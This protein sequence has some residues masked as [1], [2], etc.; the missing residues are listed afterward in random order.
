MVP[1]WVNWP[2]TSWR[3]LSWGLVIIVI[4]LLA[5]GLGAAHWALVLLAVVSL[6]SIAQTAL[7]RTQQEQNAA[8]ARAAERTLAENSTKLEYVS[9]AIHDAIWDWDLVDD[10]TT[11]SEGIHTLFGHPASEANSTAEWWLER[12]H[13]EDRDRVVTGLEELLASSHNYWSCEYR[14]LKA[15]GSYADVYDRGY[16]NRRPHGTPVRMIGAMTDL[17]QRN[18][19]AKALA[20][21]E[22][23]LRLFFD[24]ALDAMVIQ[25]NMGRYLDANPAACKLFDLCREQLIGRSDRDF[26]ESGEE[27]RARWQQFLKDGR[28][29]GQLVLTLLDGTRRTVDVS[30]TANYL[31][32]RHFS[33]LRDITEQHD[34]ELQLRQAHKMEAV[35]RLAGGIAHDF[36]NLLNVIVGYTELIE[37]KLEPANLL[38]RY[39]DKVMYS[40]E[41]AAELTD[42]LLAFSSRKHLLAPVIL[43]LNDVISSLADRLP[44]LLGDDIEFAPRCAPDLGNVRVDRSQM[45]QVITNL[46]INA[47]DAMP[48][49]GTLTVETAQV[50]VDSRHLQPGVKMNPG[51]YVLLTVSDTGTGMDAE[52]QAHIFEPF[53]T[54]KDIGKGVGLGLA[55]VYGIVRQSGGFIRVHSEVGAGTIFRV[56]FPLVIE[57]VHLVQKRESLPRCDKGTILLAEDEPAL[58]EATSEYLQNQGFLVLQAGNGAEAL[59]VARHYQEKIDLLLTD[60]IMPVVDGK[61]LAQK[62]APL[63]PGIKVLFV[64]GYTDGAIMQED[65][66]ESSASFMQKPYTFRSLTQKIRQLLEPAARRPQPLPHP[67]YSQR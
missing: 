61:E 59:E 8:L 50:H 18:L 15:D 65:M 66:L 51:A 24:S 63:L 29:R 41:R 4:A 16:V 60:V 48:N 28:Y 6:F 12:I 13:P 9:L 3:W 57:H 36:N 56:Y 2:G 10:K 53:F 55:T 62:I 44:R 58:R 11:W 14:F 5:A 7:L 39:L 33:V 27:S 64:S 31:P 40:A 17:T 19:S 52:T 26:W 22:R 21:R 32:G 38:H 1:R 49:G 47:R 67:E 45:E 43:N 34:L 25:D 54:T 30:A 35:G 23:Q 20:E 46:V 37:S 42:R